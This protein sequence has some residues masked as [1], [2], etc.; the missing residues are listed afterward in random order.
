MYLLSHFPGGLVIRA[1]GF[2]GRVV[3]LIPD[4]ELRSHRT[5]GIENKKVI[6]EDYNFKDGVKLS[7]IFNL[8]ELGEGKG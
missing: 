8:P 1:L 6:Y 2:H 4:M 3:G 5:C 7:S